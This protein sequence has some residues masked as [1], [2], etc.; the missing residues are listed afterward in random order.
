MDTREQIWA[1]AMRAARRG[2]AAVYECLLGEIAEVL[3]RLIRGRLARLGWAA[4]ETEDLVQEILI[5]LHT[6]RH[7]WDTDRPFLPWLYAIAR[8]KIADGAR[9]LRRE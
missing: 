8:Y 5:G 1:E 9:H 3:R 6:K 7:T 2:D 4:H